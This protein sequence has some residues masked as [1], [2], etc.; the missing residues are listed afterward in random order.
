M[1]Q[2]IT[3]MTKNQIINEAQLLLHEVLTGVTTAIVS[4]T[5]TPGDGAKLLIGEAIDAILPSSGKFLRIPV[6]GIP[7]RRL[8]GT[9]RI[10]AKLHG[11][12]FIAFISKMAT[13]VVN[14][15][16]F[17]DING[18][19]DSLR[20]LLEVQQTTK[21]PFYAFLRWYVP[22]AEQARTGVMPVRAAAIYL[23]SGGILA[24]RQMLASIGMLQT[25]LRRQY[26][27]G[28]EQ[29]N[30]AQI[31]EQRQNLRLVRN[32]EDSVLGCSSGAMGQLQY[33]LLALIQTVIRTANPR[34]VSQG[35]RD[36]ESELA[37]TC[38]NIRSEK[39]RD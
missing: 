31:L 6:L 2:T 12:F 38:L 18:A 33:G 37:T 8:D 28:F 34:D 32:L 39:L 15:K 11:R 7:A 20:Q 5:M 14:P 22:V 30:T 27:I 36:L 23:Q 17:N 19:L 3:A 25:R 21:V 9:T 13:A 24:I 35:I 26:D 29:R 1:N 10:D 16:I 4:V